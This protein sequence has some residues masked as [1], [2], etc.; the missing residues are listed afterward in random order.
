MNALN[1]EFDGALDMGIRIFRDLHPAAPSAPVEQP[2]RGP[3]GLPEPRQLLHGRERGRDHHQDAGGGGR[4]PGSGG[5]A[6]Y[7]IEKFI[8][9]RRLMYWQVYLHKTVVAAELMLIEACAAPANWP[10]TAR[11]SSPARP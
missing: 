7:S 2:G 4:P 1:D 10:P 5:K 6:I 9:A 3:D 11:S 8:V